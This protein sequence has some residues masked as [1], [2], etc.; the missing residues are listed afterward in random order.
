MIAANPTA[1]DY[2][3][4]KY[5]VLIK[6][7]GDLISCD[8]PSDDV[9]EQAS[10]LTEQWAW[11]NIEV[12]KVARAFTKASQPAL[13]YT[14]LGPGLWIDHLH[15][16]GGMFDERFFRIIAY[17]MQMSE[18]NVA[19]LHK[20]S[21]DEEQVV[22]AYE[23][24]E[25]SDTGK[26]IADAFIVTW[27][28]RGRLHIELARLRGQ[29][30]VQHPLRDLFQPATGPVQPYELTNVAFHLSAIALNLA[31]REPSI[32]DR[33]RSWA[34][35]V[36]LARNAVASRQ[37]DLSPRADSLE[38]MGTA[39]DVALDIGVHASRPEVDE[40]VHSGMGRPL[41][42]VQ[43]VALA[44]WEVMAPKGESL[45]GVPGMRELRPSEMRQR[46][47]DLGDGPA[48]RV[49]PIWQG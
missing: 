8:R 43:M 21:Q 16:T 2:E 19:R 26:L 46:L 37:V 20:V 49:R 32:E 45:A 22:R 9:T 44:P 5:S 36:F 14:R 7:L 3:V 48:G 31:R 40:A 29:Q 35:V 41:A 18:K 15:R 6:A 1:G 17:V 38:A 23:N 47:Y 33:I 4:G 24:L 12:L 42:T 34:R 39:V 27:L 13:G 30:L 28:L 25:T 10:K 11:E